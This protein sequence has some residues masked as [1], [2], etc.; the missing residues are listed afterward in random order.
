MASANVD[1]SVLD[2]V[3]T[4]RDLIELF[5]GRQ[6]DERSFR[7]ARR[8]FYRLV[9]ANTDT[10]PVFKLGPRQYAARPGPSREWLAKRER[11]GVAH[12]RKKRTTHARRKVKVGN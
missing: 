7:K 2:E 10:I 5:Y 1:P 6:A 4:G 9:E 12:R 11:A 8:K 3:M